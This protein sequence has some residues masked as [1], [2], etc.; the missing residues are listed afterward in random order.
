MGKWALLLAMLVALSGCFEPT[1]DGSSMEAMERSLSTL[2]KDLSKQQQKDLQQALKLIAFS[3]SGG[4]LMMM[5][6]P[7]AAQQHLQDA[8]N[9]K[10]FEQIL[11]QAQL[12]ESKAQQRKKEH[13]PEGES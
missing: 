2:G 7:Q 5:A 8:L 6:D 4:P 1:V 11:Q 13:A 10:T 9:G 3:E 12:I